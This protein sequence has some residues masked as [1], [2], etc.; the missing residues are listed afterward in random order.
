MIDSIVKNA[1][2]HAYMFDLCIKNPTVSTAYVP[3]VN[4]VAELPE[5]IDK[6]VSITPE[7]I[8]GEKRTGKS[9]LSN[10]DTTFTITYTVVP[11]PLID[12]TDIPDLSSKLRYLLSTF[13][14]YSYFTYK[15]K[16]DIAQMFLEEYRG[17]LNLLDESDSTGEEIVYD[18][19]GGSTYGE[20]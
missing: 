7:L 12:D 8:Y 2:N 5:D 13:A 3:V 6:I 10:R 20:D 4:G 1:I 9:I 11:E 14:C 15:K 17:Q 16:T 19:I 18:A